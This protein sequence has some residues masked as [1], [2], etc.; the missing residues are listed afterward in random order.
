RDERAVVGPERDAKIHLED[1]V[2][3]E[4]QPVSA[5]VRQDRSAKTRALEA[6]ATQGGDPTCTVGYGPDVLRC[7]NNH[8]QHHEQ[9]GVHGSG[10]TPVA[11]LACVALSGTSQAGVRSGAPRSRSYARRKQRP[12][13]S[14]DN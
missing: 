1:A 12:Q 4:E 14:A 7:R 6:P 5:P 9:P 8:V 2:P 13:L 10:S 3:P 11:P